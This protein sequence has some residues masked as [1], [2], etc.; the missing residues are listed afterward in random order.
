MAST[1]STTAC[2]MAPTRSDV[3]PPPGP[4]ALYSTIFAPGATP[5]IF[6]ISGPIVCTPS[7]TPP[8]LV[9]DVCEPWPSASRAVPRYR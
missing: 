2:S 6:A 7:T 4:S 8:A 9:P 5:W 1:W 3:Y